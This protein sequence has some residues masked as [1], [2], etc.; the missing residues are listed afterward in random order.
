MNQFAEKL[1]NWQRQHGRHNLPWQTSDPYRV[2]LSEIMLQQTQVA[3]V[4]E[5]YPKF[6]NRFPDVQSLAEAEQ[7]AVLQ[8]WAGLG[9]YSRARN[10][11]KAAQQI[12][13]EFGG[14]FPQQR[15]ELERLCGV[16]RST[17]AAIAAFA[18]RQPET[19]LDGN[20][21]RVLCRIF[22]LDGDTSD[23][24]FEAQLWQL[25]ESLLPK[26]QN[27]MPAYTQGLMDLGATVCKRS[28]PDCT[29][30]P[31]VSDCLAWAQNRVAELP[32]KKS[33]VP[34]KHIAFYWLILRRDDGAIWL[35]KRPQKGIWA[36]L[37]CVPCLENLQEIESFGL[38]G[39]QEYAVLT[40]RLTH[41]LLKITPLLATHF[42]RQ[43]EDLGSGVWV[44]PQNWHEYGLPKP[45]A[46]FLPQIVL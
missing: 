2:W 17:A 24:K 45:L 3:T 36:G 43:P 46:Q 10:L 4:L 1:I 40:H 42:F 5:Y 44:Q 21:K 25:A 31:M 7:D 33:A 30:C 32:R 26:N 8:L 28:K 20:V 16:G 11:H 6:I 23:K 27:D 35:Q 13:H 41:R 39:W 12:V 9:Y 38:D 34:I 18:F 14:Q 15:I 29:H 37:Y 19:I 22:A